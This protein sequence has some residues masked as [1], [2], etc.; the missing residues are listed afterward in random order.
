MEIRGEG[1]PSKVGKQIYLC[2]SDSGVVTGK[3]TVLGQ[4]KLS[5]GHCSCVGKTKKKQ[6]R[7]CKKARKKCKATCNA[8]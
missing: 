8:C 6:K 1:C 7:K 3:A 2:A 4:K 5:K